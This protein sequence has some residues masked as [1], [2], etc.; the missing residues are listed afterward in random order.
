MGSTLLLAPR[1]G[2]LGTRPISKVVPSR[3]KSGNETADGRIT[4]VSHAFVDSE[5]SHLVSW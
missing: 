1:R 5:R 4:Y 3:S 2:S